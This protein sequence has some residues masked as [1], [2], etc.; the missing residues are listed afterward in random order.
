MGVMALAAG[1]GAEITIIVDGNDEE[2]AIEQLA[3]MLKEEGL[4]E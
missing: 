4:A 2:A 3:T 1:K